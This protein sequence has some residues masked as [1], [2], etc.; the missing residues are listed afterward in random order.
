MRKLST[1][2]TR[3]AMLASLAALAL[4]DA[5]AAEP[6]AAQPADDDAI[7]VELLKTGLFLLGGGGCQSL[8]RLNAAGCVLVDGKRAGTY[9]PLMSVIRRIN[10]L[11]DLPLRGVIYTNHHDVHSGNHAEFVRG[12]VSVLVQDHARARLPPVTPVSSSAASRPMPSRPAGAVGGFDQEHRFTMG[13]VA[14]S[15]HHVGPARTD[16]DCAVLFPDLKTLAVGELY[17]PERLLPDYA[18]GGSL[19]GWRDTLQALTGLSFDD[20]VPSAGR[21]ETRTAFADFVQRTAALVERAV[22]LV[23]DDVPK[24]DFA[25]QWRTGDLGWHDRFNEQ[26]IDL[27]YRDL[28]RAR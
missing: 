24:S 13:G 11:S 25:A 7:T 4:A 28:S 1:S 27:V 18:A 26:D 19:L 23:R 22:Q 12:G 21:P 8:L 6:M 16:N 14:M 9:R 20:V 5:T 10:R 17:A 2:A 3:R 15:L